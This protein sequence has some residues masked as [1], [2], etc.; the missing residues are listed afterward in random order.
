VL[1][2]F[3]GLAA[4]RG[5]SGSTPGW[6]RATPAPACRWIEEH[7]GW[8]VEAVRHRPKARGEWV[9][10]RQ[11]AIRVRL[12]ARTRG[13]NCAVQA[14]RDPTL[15]THIVTAAGH[16]RLHAPVRHGRHSV[17]EW[18][19]CSGH[20]GGEPARV[21][22]SVNRTQTAE[23]GPDPDRPSRGPAA[24]VRRVQAEGAVRTG[25]V[26]V[27]RELRQD[28]P[29]VLLVDH[30]YRDTRGVG[31]RPGV[32]PPCSPAVPAPASGGARRRAAGPS[33]RSRGRTGRRGRG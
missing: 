17:Q 18:A 33:A 31:C 2:P 12:R 15:F 20:D 8:S 6:T 16:G 24:W 28:D 25:G 5:E 10:G 27:A 23:D 11:I 26:V 7:L 32:P 14:H 13:A 21:T 22:M 4:G 29:Q 30:E 19:A 9:V 1:E 3:A